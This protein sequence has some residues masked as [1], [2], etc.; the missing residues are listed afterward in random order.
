MAS[1]R[2]VVVSRSLPRLVRSD[3]EVDSIRLSGPPPRGTDT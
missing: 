2:I 1:S 3:F